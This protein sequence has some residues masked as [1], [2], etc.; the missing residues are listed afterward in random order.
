MSVMLERY[1]ELNG[2]LV[3]MAENGLQVKEKTVKM[4]RTQKNESL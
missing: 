1:F 2:Y 4:I 3:Q